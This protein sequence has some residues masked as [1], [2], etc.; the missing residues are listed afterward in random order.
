MSMV[1]AVIVGNLT[2]DPQLHVFNTGKTKAT[3][4]LA[5]NYP[6]PRDHNVELVEYY[7]VELWGRTAEN[8]SKYLQKGNQIVASGRFS[9]DRWT[10]Q[11]GK[12]R[13]TPVITAT[14]ITFP[15]RGNK[16][17]GNQYQSSESAQA[18]RVAKTTFV[19]APC[20]DD[21]PI[22]EE[23]EQMATPTAAVAELAD[24]EQGIVDED[25]V[26][27]SL[28]AGARTV[29]VVAEPRSHYRPRTRIAP[30]RC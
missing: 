9:L 27:D 18:T 30:M 13:T 4:S 19:P 24:Y 12:E 8:A 16:S 3:L 26:A 2:R 25:S 6:S 7:R 23:A 21:L 5:V 10:D 28:L 15:Q 22:T 11:S 20:S 14:Q 17:N 29:S 1:N